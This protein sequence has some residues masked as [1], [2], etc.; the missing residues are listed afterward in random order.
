MSVS[1]S[2]APVR[3]DSDRPDLL[4]IGA[5]INGLAIARDAARR[6]LHVL[7]VDKGD[8]GSATSQ[9]SSRMIHGGL[10]YL[11]YADFALVRESLREREYLFR[12][13]PHLVKPM[14]IV[15]TVFRNGTRRMMTVETGMVLYDLLSFDK[16]VSWHRYLS[17]QRIGQL[18]PGLTTRDLVGGSLYIDGQVPFSERLC[19]ELALDAASHGAEVQTYTELQRFEIQSARVT[20]GFLVNRLNGARRTVFP[21]YV[22]NA[23]G[24]WVDS[25]LADLGAAQAKLVGGTK[26]SHI[27]LAPFPNAPQYAVHFETE[28]GKP[29]LCM[30]WRGVYL[31]GSTDEIWN[32]DDAS[33]AS[34]SSEEFELLL[35]QMQRLFP[36]SGI[37]R[38]HVIG[39]FAG[40]RPLPHSPAKSAMAITRRH[41]VVR[42]APYASNLY[43]IVGGKLTT[44]RS[45]AEETLDKIC[46]DHFLN[47]K[48]CDTAKANFPGAISGTDT[49]PFSHALAI[50]FKLP[51]T[52]IDELV[53]IYGKFAE[54]IL[55]TWHKQKDKEP[56]AGFRPTLYS[57]IEHARC[58]E[59]ARTADDLVS[60]RLMTDIGPKSEAAREILLG[61]MAT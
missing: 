3:R 36:R 12:A 30:P 15:L 18:V 11:E 41:H 54:T 5:G 29:L 53:A 51:R 6:G 44:H 48:N 8:L 7:I 13:A 49:G 23:A 59:W 34:I 2:A 57:E 43:S 9:A 40:V 52:I 58:N 19:V 35:A 4:V 32:G 42:H 45:L 50:E 56:I 38:E 46:A 14:P 20:A 21:R 55:Q 1:V 17:R 26:G 61:I 25:V 27:A 16:S 39:S 10:R 37:T 22:V 28:Q 24:P 60:R 31:V 33:K 47:I